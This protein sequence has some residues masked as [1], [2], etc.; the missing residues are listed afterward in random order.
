VV[1]YI[2]DLMPLFAQAARVLTPGGLF[3]LTLQQVTGGEWSVGAD[4]RYA[5]TADYLRRCARDTQLD[6]AHLAMAPARREA[7]RDVPGLVA[8]LRRP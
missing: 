6:V 7:G 1:I 8:V 2:G 3:A 5:H 4:L